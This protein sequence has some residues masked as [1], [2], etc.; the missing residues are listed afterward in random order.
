MNINY[1]KGKNARFVIIFLIIKFSKCY[2][3]SDAFLSIVYPITFLVFLSFI[4]LHFFLFLF[5]NPFYFSFRDDH[6]VQFLFPLLSVSFFP[7]QFL[8]S[9]YFLGFLMIVFSAPQAFELLIKHK[10]RHFGSRMVVGQKVSV[11]H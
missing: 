11:R 2:F 10:Q 7:H 3:K 4:C 8:P 1:Y 6:I 5:N 9:S